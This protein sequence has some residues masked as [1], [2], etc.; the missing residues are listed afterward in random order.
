MPHAGRCDHW[1]NHVERHGSAMPDQPAFRFRGRTTTWG[2]LR[3]RVRALA[4]AD[5]RHLVQLLAVPGDR[6]EHAPGAPLGT[7]AG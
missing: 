1:N 4:D 7:S 3:D 2:R 5:R 6:A